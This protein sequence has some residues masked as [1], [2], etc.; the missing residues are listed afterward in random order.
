[1]TVMNGKYHTLTVILAVLGAIAAVFLAVWALY[2]FFAP[3]Y[4][5][6]YDDEA[7]GRNSEEDDGDDDACEE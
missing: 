1:M 6:G 2:L 7:G 4:Y 3:K 5:I